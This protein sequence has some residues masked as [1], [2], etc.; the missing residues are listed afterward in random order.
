V[1]DD[2]GHAAQHGAVGA[3]AIRVMEDAADAAH[4]SA[5]LGV[6]PLAPHGSNLIG[7]QAEEENDD[8]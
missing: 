8:G 5:T 3:L 1:H 2:I 6:A 4:G 7:E